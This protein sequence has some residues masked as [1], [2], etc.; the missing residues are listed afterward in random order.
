MAQFHLSSASEDASMTVTP[1]D[2]A[3]QSRPGP[4]PRR[5]AAMIALAWL[6]ALIA[7]ASLPRF[8]PTFD[9]WPWELP[10]LTLAL[11]PVGRLGVWPIVLVG[12]GLVAV[13]AGLSAGWARAGLPGRRAVV[14]GLATAG[15]GA[16]PVFMAAALGPMLT[17]PPVAQW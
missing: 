8:V 6:P 1:T 17:A 10:P 2:Q 7:A 9:R 15:L 4:S 5:A 14:L 13:L 11:M 3:L 12:V 16:L